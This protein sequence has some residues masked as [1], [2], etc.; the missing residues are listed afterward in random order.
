M[1]EKK[2]AKP[3]E[4]VAAVEQ[5]AAG[6]SSGEHTPENMPRQA[7]FLV[8]WVV[9]KCLKNVAISIGAFEKFKANALDE[10]G[11]IKADLKEKFEQA[12]AWRQEERDIR[13]TMPYAPETFEAAY[14]DVMKVVAYQKA[15]QA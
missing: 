13:A 14:R 2:A 8:Y 5:R 6:W 9:S 7:R 1:S 3:T 4:I 12:I 11:A 15:R 10:Q